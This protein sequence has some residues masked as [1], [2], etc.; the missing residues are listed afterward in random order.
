AHD[1]KAA[2]GA[3]PS[4][5]ELADLLAAYDESLAKSAAAPVD[6]AELPAQVK[7]RLQPAQSCLHL[8]EQLWPRAVR[9]E[10]DRNNCV[11]TSPPGAFLGRFHI[12]GE[13][14]RGG[15]GIVLLAWDPVLTRKVA[16]KVPQPEFLV[17][18]ELRQRFVREAKAA[19][20]L[21]HPNL[22]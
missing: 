8:L 19:A 9:A 14:G 18:A 6:L 5:R 3:S 4:D 22:V 10:L 2:E 1:M 16:L 13:L 17:N 20:V 11:A 7:S 12:Q 15:C 21:N